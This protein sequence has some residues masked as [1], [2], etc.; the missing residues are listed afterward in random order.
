MNFEAT[1]VQWE[2]VDCTQWVTGYAVRY[3]VVGSGVE[4]RT[5]TMVPSGSQSLTILGLTKGTVYSFEVAAE[6]KFGLGQYS[7]PI[8]SQTPDSGELCSITTSALIIPSYLLFSDVF[9]SLN[10]SVIPDHGY[11]KLS[12]IGTTEETA[13]I[14]HTNQPPPDGVKNTLGEWVSPEEYSIGRTGTPGS[15]S[16]MRNLAQTPEQGMYLCV[17]QDMSRFSAVEVYVG[18]YQTGE[19]T[20]CVIQRRKQSLRFNLFLAPLLS[21]DVT[22]SG[23]LVLTVD[24]DL[25]GP[26]PRFT[27][28]CVSTGGPAT[29]VTWTRD[30]VILTEGTVSVLDDPVTAQYTHNL[31]VA[32]R[33]DGTYTITVANDKPSTASATFSTATE[34]TEGT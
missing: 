11:V 14:C 31:T 32:G 19:G 16:L 8:T 13:L 3:G 21:G 25:D 9:L 4:E 1:T 12:D 7:D 34:S 20:V 30:S 26:T 15:V 18:L 10:G 24:S 17:I 6:N 29:T 2:P 22:L 28:T 33:P 5:V 27:I 23:D